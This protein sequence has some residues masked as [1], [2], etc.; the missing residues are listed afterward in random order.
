[1]GSMLPTYYLHGQPTLFCVGSMLPTYYFIA[2][3]LLFSLLP[4]AHVR[5]ANRPTSTDTSL[6]TPL[7]QRY[8]T[9]LMI[10]FVNGRC[11]YCETVFDAGKNTISNFYKHIR[12]YAT[13]GPLTR[14]KHPG[15]GSDAY[16]EIAQRFRPT[17]K[18]AEENG[19]GSVSVPMELEVKKEDEERSLKL[20]FEVRERI[21]KAFRNLMYSPGGCS[22]SLD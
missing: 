2:A 21:E 11:P 19:V 10:Q 12:L 15:F 1:M 22:L 14:K 9:L 16:K 8:P 13:K 6:P 18:S 20:S 3:H 4:W 5:T 17:A 7:L